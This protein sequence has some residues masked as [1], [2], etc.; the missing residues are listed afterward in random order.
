MPYAGPPSAVPDFRAPMLGAVL[1]EL[2][3]IC[4]MGRWGGASLSDRL[5]VQ[6]PQAKCHPQVFHL[7]PVRWG[8][9][10]VGEHPNMRLNRFWAGW[11]WA[12][13]PITSVF[14]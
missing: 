2:S 5:C 8:E 6:G 9:G 10:V 12:P 11:A 14:P 3:A 7:F 1:T 13:V 4:W